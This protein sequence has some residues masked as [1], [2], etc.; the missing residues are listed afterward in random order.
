M[1]AEEHQLPDPEMWRVDEKARPAMRALLR[2]GGFDFDAPSIDQ[3]L[4]NVHP[5]ILPESA[6]EALPPHEQE[7]YWH[8]VKV[9]KGPGW[10]HPDYVDVVVPEAFSD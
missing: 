9:L 4:A 8:E 7:V 2:L 1:G 10:R 5:V 6:V 3:A